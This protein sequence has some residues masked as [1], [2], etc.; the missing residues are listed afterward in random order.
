MNMWN[1]TPRGVDDRAVSNNLDVVV[2]G[3]FCGRPDEIPARCAGRCPSG[4]RRGSLRRGRGACRRR[5]RRRGANRSR[6][7]QEGR[8]H[9]VGGADSAAPSSTTMRMTRTR[10][11]RR[12]L[13]L[14]IGPTS[15]A[16]AGSRRR[17]GSPSTT[18]SSCTRRSRNAESTRANSGLTGSSEVAPTAAVP[19]SSEDG[20]PVGWPRDDLR[21]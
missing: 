21:C 13:R 14:L 8:V 6:G 3:P 18:A 9:L 11:R 19:T 1:S 20:R 2:G 12:V 17:R 7:V 4:W 5:N 16:L 15:D 10:E